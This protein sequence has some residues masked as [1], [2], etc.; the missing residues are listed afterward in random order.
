MFSQLLCLFPQPFLANSLVPAIELL[1]VLRQGFNELPRIFT[2]RICHSLFEPIRPQPLANYTQ[3]L[4]LKMVNNFMAQNK[5]IPSSRAN[6]DARYADSLRLGRSAKPE[7]LKT[8]CRGTERCPGLV[9]YCA[10]RRIHETQRQFVDG[11]RFLRPCEIFNAHFFRDASNLIPFR[12]QYT[13]W[14]VKCPAHY[15][16][17]Q[18]T[19]QCDSYQHA[20]RFNT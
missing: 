6:Y 9:V 12:I 3:L 4:R 16:C 15:W 20:D 17:E 19:N 13:H 11:V 5:L 7:C 2:K 10:D 14:L 1:A 18:Q 8:L